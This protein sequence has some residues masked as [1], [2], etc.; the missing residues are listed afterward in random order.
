MTYSLHGDIPKEHRDLANQLIE[1]EEYFDSIASSSDKARSAAKAYVALAHDWIDMGLEERAEILFRKS[2][3]AVPG[4]FSGLIWEDTKQDVE[5]AH[6]VANIMDY[7]N[8]ALISAL[9]GTM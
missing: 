5:F 7:L 3:K 1:M 6:L 9:K 4:Y 8:S 2:E